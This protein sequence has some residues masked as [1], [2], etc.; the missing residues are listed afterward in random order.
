MVSRLLA[1]IN[2]VE[3]ASAELSRHIRGAAGPFAQVV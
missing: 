2:F 3:K 1:D